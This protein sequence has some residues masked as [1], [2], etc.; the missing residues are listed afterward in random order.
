M[1]DMMPFSQE[2]AKEL[3]SIL[4]EYDTLKAVA[5]GPACKTFH[6]EVMANFREFV[7]SINIGR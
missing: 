1:E 2:R 7:R 4:D 6:E 3:T 5:A